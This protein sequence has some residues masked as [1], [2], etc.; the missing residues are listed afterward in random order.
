[1]TTIL[2]RANILLTKGKI[3]NTLDKIK[4]SIE[5]TNAYKS[6]YD[7]NFTV[8]ENDFTLRGF[9]DSAYCDELDLNG[10][11]ISMENLNDMQFNIDDQVMPLSSI[12]AL[13]DIDIQTAA[14]V[15]D[16]E[17]ELYTIDEDR[18]C[19]EISSPFFTGRI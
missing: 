5:I 2:Y 8:H 10:V 6:H 4:N 1:L 13:I 9:G 18:M 12:I 14:A 19:R 15:Y 7:V 17:T 11:C 16:A 3:M